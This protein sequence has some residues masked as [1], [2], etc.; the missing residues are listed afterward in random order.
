MNKP[1]IKFKDGQ[2]WVWSS[3][4]ASLDCMPQYKANTLYFSLRLIKAIK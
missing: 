1:H 2:Y 4:K 3:K